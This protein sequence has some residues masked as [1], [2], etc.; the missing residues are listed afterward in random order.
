LRS[1]PAHATEGAA[2]SKSAAN[3]VVRKIGTFNR[4]VIGVSSSVVAYEEL[5]VH[6]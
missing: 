2:T 5:L 3:K 6:H 4:R 1:S